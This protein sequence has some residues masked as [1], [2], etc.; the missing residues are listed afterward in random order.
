MWRV[1]RNLNFWEWGEEPCQYTHDAIWHITIILTKTAWLG[2][3]LVTMPQYTMYYKI[4]AMIVTK[5]MFGP[6]IPLPPVVLEWYVKILEC[7]VQCVASPEL[8]ISERH[9][10]LRLSQIPV[11]VLDSYWS[12]TKWYR[13][14]DPEESHN[15]FLWFGATTSQVRAF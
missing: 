11:W 5:K 13:L 4:I 6:N 9:Y 12:L 2:P 7:Q 8:K 14:G 1:W 15:P 10:N 3:R